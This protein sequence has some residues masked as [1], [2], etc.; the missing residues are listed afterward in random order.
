MSDFHSLAELDG[1]LVRDGPF[2]FLVSGGWNDY[3]AGDVF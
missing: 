2:H 3:F 1:V